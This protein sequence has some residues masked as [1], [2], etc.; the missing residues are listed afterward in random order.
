MV[1]WAYLLSHQVLSQEK[2]SQDLIIITEKDVIVGAQQTEQYFPILKNVNVAVVA[3]QTSMIG[4]V[5][6][7]DSLL[8][9]GVI[10]TKVFCPEHGFRGQADAGK[11]IKSGRD[12]QT[13]LPVIS[14]YGKHYKPTNKELKKVDIVVFDLQDV[15]ARFYT[16]ISTMSFVMEA[17]AERG[18]P[19]IILDRPNPNGFYVDGPILT[20]Q[21]Q[22]FVGL[23]PVPIVHGMTVGEYAS[24]VNGEGWL[25]GDF[26]C[27]IKVIPVINYH[28]NMLYKLPVKPSPNLPNWKAIYLYPSLALFEGTIISEGRGTDKPFQIIGH[29]DF[30][31]GSYTFTPHSITGAVNPKYKDQ[32]CIG[33]N[34][35][36]YASNIKKNPRQ[37][38]LR[39]LIDM[40]RFFSDRSD[41]FNSYFNYLSGSTMLKAQI[42]LGVNE[43]D[44]RKSWEA[45]LKEF[46]EIRK[47]YL[48]YPDFE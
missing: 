36:N 22:S 19:M 21:Y 45:G 26:Y 34:L 7:V 41:F 28:H 5:H 13:G 10:V 8:N 20:G 47:N 29:P 31:H 6:L 16:Y 9:S 14:L 1:V 23:H 12:A 2:P 42:K 38:H 43:K 35:T 44:I 27:D 40:A 33:Q 4:K 48:L 37:I 24:M 18:I 46:K 30:K 15:G 39:W 11:N 25:E 32:R 17:C 3:N